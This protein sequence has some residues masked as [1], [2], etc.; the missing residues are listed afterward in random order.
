MLGNNAT[1]CIS[2]GTKVVADK[3]YFVNKTIG[4]KEGE[5]YHIFDIVKNAVNKSLGV[6]CV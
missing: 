3:M 5:Q 1:I 2:S 4:L 6:V